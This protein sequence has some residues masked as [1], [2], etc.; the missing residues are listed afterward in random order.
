MTGNEEHSGRSRV[1]NVRLGGLVGANDPSV[2]V[3][4][5]GTCNTAGARDG[6]ETRD[7]SRER[8]GRPGNRGRSTVDA[9]R[10]RDLVCERPADSELGRVSE[11]G[12]T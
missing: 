10:A 3:S 12:R 11:R 7:A 8:G 5:L 1:R 2:S 9:A 6:V 4:S